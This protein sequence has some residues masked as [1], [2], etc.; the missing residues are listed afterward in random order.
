[1]T[2]LLSTYFACTASVTA[3]IYND[4]NLTVSVLNDYKWLFFFYDFLKLIS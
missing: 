3:W 2:G 4:H 1:M